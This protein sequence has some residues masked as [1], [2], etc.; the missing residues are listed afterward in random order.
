MSVARLVETQWRAIVVIVVL[1]AIGG[2]AG[3]ARVPLSLLPA[4]NF[5]R[6][7]IVI[8]NGEVPAQQML[9]TVTRPVEEA[10]S[11]IPG[12]ARI[13]SVTSRGAAEIDLFFD[14]HAD[15]EQT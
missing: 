6:I 10:M 15:I 11:G 4:T 5:T 13:R 8:E 14:W 1:L 9:V 12:I 7:I 2:L 3:L